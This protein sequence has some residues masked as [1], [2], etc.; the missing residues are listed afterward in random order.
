MC[1]CINLANCELAQFHTLYILASLQNNF[2]YN[3]WHAMQ[4]YPSTHPKND[5]FFDF[6][7][8]PKT[9]MTMGEVFSQPC[10]RLGVLMHNKYAGLNQPLYSSTC[11]SS[12]YSASCCTRFP[13]C[14]LGLWDISFNHLTKQLK[15]TLTPYRNPYHM[16]IDSLTLLV[17]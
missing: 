16:F 17:L 11:F 12:H 7:T 10:S 8:N 6:P 14:S 4:L 13:V 9:R 1:K 5:N 2:L 3:V 15:Y